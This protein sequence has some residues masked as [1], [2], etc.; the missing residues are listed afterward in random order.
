[1]VS[2]SGEIHNQNISS[3]KETLHPHDMGDGPRA[4]SAQ[5]GSRLDTADRWEK[6]SQR[7][8]WRSQA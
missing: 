8:P 7:I 1:M 6:A 2:A 3:P 4:Q 5:S